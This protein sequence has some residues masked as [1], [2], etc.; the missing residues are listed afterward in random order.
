MLAARTLAEM[1]AARGKAHFKRNLTQAIEVIAK[2]LGNTKAVCR[3]CYIHPAVLDGYRDGSLFKVIE[4]S[5]RRSTATESSELSSEEAAILALLER[6][7]KNPPRLP[8][9]TRLRRQLG[10]SLERAKP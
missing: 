1:R 2:Q 5:T 7:S 6:N 3:K 4:R 9:R 8:N 10:K